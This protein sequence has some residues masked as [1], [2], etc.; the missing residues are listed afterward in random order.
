MTSTSSARRSGTYIRTSAKF[1]NAWC[2]F[3][4]ELNGPASSQEIVVFDIDRAIDRRGGSEF[5]R[6]AYPICT[7]RTDDAPACGFANSDIAHSIGKVAYLIERI[8]RR[9]SDDQIALVCRDRNSHLDLK[10]MLFGMSERN[11]VV[12][13]RGGGSRGEKQCETGGEE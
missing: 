5:A 3:S 1:T 9:Q 10:L 7:E 8:P 11:F 2:V 13:R 6:F 12:D 4:C